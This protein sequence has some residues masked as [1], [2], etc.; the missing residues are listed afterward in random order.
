[1]TLYVTVETKCTKSS[2]FVHQKTCYL[3]DSIEGLCEISTEEDNNIGFIRDSTPHLQIM[4][5]FLINDLAAYVT[6][7]KTGLGANFE[8]LGTCYR[9]I[10]VSKL[11]TLSKIIKLGSRFSQR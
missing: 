5:P 7:R 1:M 2:R 6:A 8:R 10:D 3:F 4:N 11:P 9:Y